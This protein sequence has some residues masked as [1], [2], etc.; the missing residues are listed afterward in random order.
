MDKIRLIFKEIKDFSRFIR[1]TAKKDKEI[2]FYSEHKD[3]HPY[4]EGIIK[5]LIDNYSH[6][7]CY[8]TSEADDPI[9]EKSDPQIKTFYLDKL[10]PFFMVFVNCKV[11]VLTLTDLNRFHLKRSIH[12][13]K[14]VYVFHSLAST[15]M[16][17]RFGAYDHYDYLLCVGPY[18][19]NEI[20]KREK[21]YNLPSKNLL[22]GGYYRLERIYNS[23]IKYIQQNLKLSDRKIVLIAPSWGEK[24]ILEFCG[25]RLID[26]L[27]KNNFEV[28]VR[29][30]PETVRHS[31]Y[32]ISSLTD[33]FGNNSHFTLERSIST[34]SSLLKA[35]ILICDSSGVALEFA[36]G[37]ERPVLFIDVP[38]QI[39]NPRYR[40]LGIEPLEI[41]IR[42]DIGSV[43]AP[44]QLGTIPRI[45]NDLISKR[46]TYKSHLA[47]LRNQNIFSFG[48]S[49]EIG[50]KCIFDLVTNKGNK[51][52]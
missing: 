8:V 45:I 48:H 6:P 49:S 38:I 26:I 1:K 29:P 41:S 22:E 35:D 36:F 17:F 13:V 2:V 3:Y 42:S 23:Y 19:V 33:R 18:Q 31:P 50:S 40:E 32:L 46:S 4:F 34:D 5:E 37:T 25:D 51:K 52:Q 39:N 16:K 14:Y 44:N 15:H 47:Q 9:L 28:I 7:I 43:V 20:R 10:L 24:N 27:L 21:L 30:H 12:P 11:F